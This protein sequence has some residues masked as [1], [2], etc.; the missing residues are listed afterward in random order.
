MFCYTGTM[1]KSSDRPEG[2]SQHGLVL[3]MLKNRTATD[4]QCAIW[5]GYRHPINGYGRISFRGKGRYTHRLV[6]ADVTGRDIDDISPDEKCLHTCGR[7]IEGCITPSH[8][9][10]GTDADNVADAIAHGTHLGARTHCVRGHILAGA[11]LPATFR[12]RKKRHCRLCGLALPRAK[13][14][15]GSIEEA[16]AYVLSRHPDLAELI[17]ADRSGRLTP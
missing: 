11:N 13:R 9:R 12:T 16:I 10:W 2:L 14:S 6:L 7:G 8:L 5:Q 15:G 1:P 3:W 17:E 4:G